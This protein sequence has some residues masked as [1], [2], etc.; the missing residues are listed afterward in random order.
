MKNNMNENPDN[1]NVKKGTGI[2]ENDII[3]K[4]QRQANKE[5]LA[6]GIIATSVIAIIL[7]AA[8]GIYG[9]S[10]IKSE[11]EKQVSMLENQSQKFS[12]QLTHRDSVINEWV[13]TFDQIEKDLSVVKDQQQIIKLKSSDR[14]FTEERKQQV[15]RDIEYI[16]TLLDQ[17]KT[18]IASLNAQLIKSGGSLKILQD[19]IAELEEMMITRENEIN[20]LKS[21]LAKKD[22]EIEEL[23]VRMADMQVTILKKDEEIS[24]QINSMNR[25]FLVSGT[26]RELK[27]KGLVIK[28]GGFLGIG[29]KESLVKDFVD[30]LF[31]Q[32]NITETLKIPVNSKIVKLITD[33]P[34]SSYELIPD[35]ENKIAYIE[36]KDPYQFWKLSKYAVVE[37]KN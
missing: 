2:T 28:D 13:T 26:F 3:L 10:L 30:T 37:T 8:A 7:L 22:F 24:Q 36:I 29:K 6:T 9:N 21:A 18:K 33:H 23:N 35:K 1:K 17:N 5:G 12:E 32:V 27:E 25:A 34:A 31:A 14:E 20:E 11:K 15:L 16:N 4:D 19:K